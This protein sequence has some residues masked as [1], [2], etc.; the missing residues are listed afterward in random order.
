MS[1]FL[2]ALRSIPGPFGLGV[3]CLKTNLLTRFSLPEP[4][5]ALCLYVTYQCNFRCLMCGIWQIN[6]DNDVAPDMTP[7]EIETV[8]SDPLFRRLEFV[9]INGGEPNLRTDLPDIVQMLIRTL[10]RLKTITLNSN[11][12]PVNRT[13]RNIRMISPLCRAHGIRFSISI[14][15]HDL[16]DNFDVIAGRKQAFAKVSRTLR[17]LKKLQPEMKFFLSINCVITGL[18]LGHLNRLRKWG[19]Q[20]GIPVNYTLGEIRER[21]LN[22]SMRDVFVSGNQKQK[23]IRFFNSLAAEKS[24]FNHHAYRYKQLADMLQSPQ[25]RHMP[26]HYYMFG[27]ILGSDGQLYYCKDSRSLGNCRSEPAFRLYYQSENLDYRR[28]HLRQRKCRSC[29]PNTF[30]RFEFEKELPRYIQFLVRK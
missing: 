25:S 12:V 13:V 4:P 30:N 10:P 8:L 18:N 21:F 6:K 11:G 16:G 20:E 23:L 14:S 9:N 27:A 19:E 28:R 7:E 24:F 5:K 29:P 22:E 3:R 15:L 26:C 2:E 17:E 1:V